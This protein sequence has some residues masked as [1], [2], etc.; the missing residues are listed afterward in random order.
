MRI[1]VD[2][3]TGYNNVIKAIMSVTIHPSNLCAVGGL[4]RQAHVFWN[5]PFSF[6]LI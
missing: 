2:P 5:I 4:I 1:E 3:V 6:F